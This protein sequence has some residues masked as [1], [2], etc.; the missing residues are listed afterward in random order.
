MK[1]QVGDLVELNPHLSGDVLSYYNQFN[2]KPGVLYKVL[3]R[4][5]ARYVDIHGVSGE[6]YEAVT[7]DGKNTLFLLE[8]DLGDV[9]KENLKTILE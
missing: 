5:E 1:Y 2:F 6:V 8:G 3:R 4:V 7:L 9:F